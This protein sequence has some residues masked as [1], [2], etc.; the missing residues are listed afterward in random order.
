MANLILLMS[1]IVFTACS[2]TAWAQA[3]VTMPKIGFITSSARIPGGNWDSIRAKLRELGYIEGKTVVLEPRFGDERVERLPDLAADLVRRNVDVIMT[4]G[5]SAT[6]AAKQATS[7]I[8]IVMLFD[9]DPVQA[10]FVASLAQPG[11]NI[12]GNSS[13]SPELIGKQIE[14]LKAVLP[15]MSRLAILGNSTQPGNSQTLKEAEAAASALGLQLVPLDARV[16]GDVEPA[17]D[18]ASR[19]GAEA[20]VVM[21]TPAAVLR[22]GR[23]LELVEKRRMPAMYYATGFVVNDGGLMAYAADQADES[24]RAAIYVDKILKGAK[25]S[26]LPVEMPVKFV[27]IVNLK[28]A[29]RIG[30]TLPPAVISRADQVVD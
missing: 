11:G 15:R 8:P 1:L 2:S 20:I 14:L 12:T 22:E 30:L 25:A 28:A 26:D 5:P 29:K 23:F 4:A 7:R 21:V 10:G 19:A 27:L 6:R 13:V 18:V 9:P 24:R 3:A 16:P 17:L